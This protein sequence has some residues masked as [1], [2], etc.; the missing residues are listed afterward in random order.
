MKTL[1]LFAFI[2]F[3]MVAIQCSKESGPT[4]PVADGIYGSWN[5]VESVGGISGNN[6][7]TPASVGYSVKI[8]FLNNG[9][10][11]RFQNDS[12]QAT[13][14]FTVSRKKTSF[15]ADTVNLIA[16]ADSIHFMPQ[17]IYSVTIDSLFLEDLYPDGLGHAYSRIK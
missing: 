8:N 12:L 3:S 7:L 4:E 5:W 9:T 14:T 16:Y 17:I 1:S 15:H 2:L 13:T 10:F 6:V 11:Q